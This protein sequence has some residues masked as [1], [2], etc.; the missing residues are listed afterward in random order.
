MH[1]HVD[2]SHKRAG[3]SIAVAKQLTGSDTRADVFKL[4][5][6][7]HN[8]QAIKAAENNHCPEV[9]ISIPNGSAE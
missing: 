8:I 3:L 6:L 9:K 2:A 4:K 1:R 5:W 7:T